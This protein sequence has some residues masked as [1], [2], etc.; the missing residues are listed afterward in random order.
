MSDMN[1]DDDSASF[2]TDDDD[3]SGNES[4]NGNE[5]DH[6]GVTTMMNNN[7]DDDDEEYGN[8]D[9]GDDT[10][11]DDDDDMIDYPTFT[12]GLSL[13]HRMRVKDARRVLFDRE[14]QRMRP[15]I[16]SQIRN[17]M[18]DEWRGVLTLP[19]LQ[20]TTFDFQLLKN[21]L[22]S[23]SSSSQQ[24]QQQQQHSDEEDD[25]GE[26]VMRKS[27]GGGDHPSS[28][29]LRVLQA[30]QR[31]DTWRYDLGLESSTVDGGDGGDGVDGEGEE[32][33]EEGDTNDI[34]TY[35]DVTV[36]LESDGNESEEDE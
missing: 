19:D 1:A 8:S 35:S 32:G 20:S 12:S 30:K 14:A 22:S 6:D 2:Y 4:D 36:D 34:D 5:R 21:L 15:M 17:D 3:D 29:R 28:D 23:S 25:I 24:Q 9:D 26:V 13:D 10:D 11:D 7:N 27:S 18:D 16:E 31:G 33:S